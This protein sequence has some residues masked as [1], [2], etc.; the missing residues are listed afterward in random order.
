MAKS[1]ARFEYQARLSRTDH[2]LSQKFGFTTAPGILSPIFADIATPG[3]SYYIKHDLS[4][5]RTAPL[6]APSMI[7]VKVHFESFFVPMQMI[8]QPFENSMFSLTEILSSNYKVADFQ[9]QNLPL[10][11]PDDVWSF[12]GAGSGN[13]E[14]K[15]RLDAFRLF[16]LLDLPTLGF[17]GKVDF[18][19]QFGNFFPW[20]L[21][22]YQCI[23]QHYYRLD[24]KEQ[25]DHDAFNL[26]KYYSLEDFV[27][28]SSVNLEKFIKLHYRPWKF[29]YFTSS[30]MSPIVSSANTQS[31]LPVGRYTDL[32]SFPAST[33]NIIGRTSPITRAGVV[34]DNNEEIVAYTSRFS[35]SSDSTNQAQVS[36]AMI[37]QMFANEKLAM[38]T[39]RTKKNY[40]SQVLAHYGVPVPH[41]VKHDISFIGHDEYELKVGEVTSL[42]STDLSPLGDLA[43]KGWAFGEAKKTHKFTAP[44]HGVIMTIF[45]VEPMIRYEGTSQRI[46]F[47]SS[48]LD[49][50]I[51]EYDRLGNQ[52]M[53]YREFD[54]HDTPGD[55]LRDV[56]GIWKER[57]Y[58]SKRRYDRVSQAFT[59]KPVQGFTRDLTNNYAA[60]F[61][62]DTPFTIHPASPVSYQY[63]ENA[64]YINPSCLDALMLVS[65]SD[66]WLDGG[67]QQAP[68]ED[69]DTYPYLAFARDP[70]IVDSNIQVKKVSWMSK[71]G[72]PIYPY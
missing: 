71:D 41:D 64:Y 63:S 46:N 68:T 67:T 53:F 66:S 56:S 30:Y 9:N 52:P 55:I 13:I 8:Y 60:Y 50:P 24:D 39:G 33:S 72:E 16:D 25:F 43:G 32:V 23:Y 14:P 57:Y 44:C 69:Y 61:V 22:A 62:H 65:Y 51:P 40:D 21:C 35:T 10:L 7:D 59:Q 6:I 34:S 3:D 49:I 36:T 15:I 20:Q 2:D 17:P 29:D 37:R 47:V 12:Y 11:R 4:F 5:L 1:D 48:A 45:S 54:N 42:A 70:F 26:D 58:Y 31:L 18:T 19:Y 38:I 28:Q 27:S